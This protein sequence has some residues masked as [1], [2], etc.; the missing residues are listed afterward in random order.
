[1]KFPP[2]ITGAQV[3]DNTTILLI[4][5]KNGEHRE[6]DIS[7][8]FSEPMFESLKKPNF[9]KSFVVAPGGAALVWNKDVDI[10]ENE[11]WVNGVQTERRISTPA[12]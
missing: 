11:L 1:M 3:L 5:F 9:L 7:Q 10:S 4:E 2:R 8:L 12:D 6:Y